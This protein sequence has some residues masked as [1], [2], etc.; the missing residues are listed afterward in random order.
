MT[1]SQLAATTWPN[2]FAGE[3]ITAE[4]DFGPDLAAGDTVATLQWVFSTVKGVDAV[5]AAVQYGVAQIKGARVFQ[6]L[7][8]GIAGC[9]Y[10][11]ECRATTVQNN[12][13]ILARVLPVVALLT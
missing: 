6:Q 1:T 8:A 3:R 9:S 4:F 5:P 13:L 11:V 10:L 7:A 2:K 12:I